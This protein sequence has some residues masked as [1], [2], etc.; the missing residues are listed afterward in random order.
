M[1]EA[2]RTSTEEIHSRAT[3]Q[4]HP[5]HPMI[6]VFP[7]ASLAGA[8]V[9]DI[10]FATSREPFWAQASLWLIAAGVVTGA[11][12]AVFGVI[13]FLGNSRIRSLRA[14]W[15]HAGGN[16][17]AMVLAIINLLMRLNNPA[18]SIV[19]LGLLISA[20]IAVLLVVTGWFGGELVYR[21]KVGVDSRDIEP[22]PVPGR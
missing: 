6:I 21:H 13:D 18:D 17:I 22:E 7:I 19:P 10:V 3:I 2:T 9:T 8:L 11:I 5:I 14:A 16:V 20:L 4:G 12:A 15:V 1:Q